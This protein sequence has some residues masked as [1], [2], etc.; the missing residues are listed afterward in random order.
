VELPTGGNGRRTNPDAKPASATTSAEGVGRADSG[1]IP[2]PTVIVRM[3]ENAGPE[4]LC[5]LFLFA[6]PWVT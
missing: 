6:L 1:V 2:E 4:R 5:G 3:K